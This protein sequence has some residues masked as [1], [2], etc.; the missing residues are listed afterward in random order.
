MKILLTG[1]TGFVGGAILEDL[2]QNNEIVRVLVRE[3]SDISNLK[4]CEIVRADYKK[5]ESLHGAI[6]DV[7]AI[8]HCGGI[9]RA[10]DKAAYFE[11]N[12]ENTIRL[13]RAALEVKPNLKKFVFISSQAAMGPSSS[14]NPK[15]LEDEPNPV[16]DYG[17]SKLEAEKALKGLL[18]GKIPWTILR[19]ASVYGPRDKDIFIFFS[20]VH[21]HLKPYQ[22]KKRF[23]QLLFVQD[24]AKAVR[25]SLYNELSD[26][27]TYFLAEKTSYTWE[28]IAQT[29]AQISQIKTVPLPLPD[30][31]FHLAAFFA[32]IGSK[33]S[34]KTPIL[35]RQKIKEM[36]QN[37]WISDTFPAENELKLEFTLLEKGGSITYNWYTKNEWLP[38]DNSKKSKIRSI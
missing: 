32:E 6:K 18:S 22:L 3:S 37:Y 28:Q 7:E 30:F 21:R 19:P 13:C 38:V 4:N 14:I 15:S 16:S 20:L 11:A 27:K 9:V 34:G 29:I 8:V 26:N 24:L 10:K 33:I 5:Q 36:L 12:V 17:L 23:L 31:I 25:Y 1:A 2:T 35:N